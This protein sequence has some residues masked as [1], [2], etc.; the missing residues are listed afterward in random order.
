M[1]DILWVL[2][3]LELRNLVD[4]LLVAGVFYGVLMLVRGTQA[5]QLIKGTMLVAIVLALIGSIA[6]LTAFNWLLRNAAQA[7]L[8]VVV[9]VLQP[10]LRRALD[11]LGRAS[12]ITFLAESDSAVDR[13]IRE[14]ANSCGR[15]SEMHHGALIVIERETGLQDYI[16]TGVSIH[17]A[18][19]SELLQ[20]VFFPNTA[21]HDG[22]VIIRGNE[23]V[24]AACLLPLTE[25]VVSDVHLGTRHRAAIGITET[26]DAIALVVSEETG[27][28]SM[29]RSGRI[30]RHLDERRL[31]T[32]LQT[33][34][35]PEQA[36]KGNVR[37]WISRVLD[38]LHVQHKK[39]K[40][41]L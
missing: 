9:I 33:L 36:R 19:V 5:M 6:G 31:V 14:I 17:S 22:A 4:I 28:I 41:Q 11:R 20:T 30:V 26:T 7:L 2:S 24:A 34:L 27:I 40:G 16:D 1:T 15:L 21:L 39:H 8:I 29:A 37:D 12:G 38:T 3:K 23:I 13:T 10:E 32:L 35:K 18:V 25:S